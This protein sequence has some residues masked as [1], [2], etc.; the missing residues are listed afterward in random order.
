[1]V[2]GLWSRLLLVFG[3]TCLLRACCTDSCELRTLHPLETRLRT[4]TTT[5]QPLHGVW[6]FG[7]LFFVV[8]F[9]IYV[10]R[11][12]LSSLASGLCGLV[13]RVI[14]TVNLCT[15]SYFICSCERSSRD[16]NKSNSTARRF[17][18]LVLT[19]RRWFSFV[20]CVSSWASHKAH[21]QSWRSRIS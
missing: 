7:R 10:R 12:F 1:M 5:V 8:F 21:N 17:N 4:T 19:F 18:I 15:C 20:S 16:T 13:P 6:T 3:P 9:V 11:F 14:D 2:S